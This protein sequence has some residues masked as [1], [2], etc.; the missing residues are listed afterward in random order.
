LESVIP[1]DYVHNVPYVGDD[2]FLAGVDTWGGLISG[3]VPTSDVL[4]IP[5]SPF[6]HKFDVPFVVQKPHVTRY[7]GRVDY[8]RYYEPGSSFFTGFPDKTFNHENDVEHV[9]YRGNIRDIHNDVVLDAPLH[10]GSYPT[11]LI[12]GRP[13][14][15]PFVGLAFDD[16]FGGAKGCARVGTDANGNGIFSLSTG[17]PRNNYRPTFRV[18]QQLAAWDQW[19]HSNSVVTRYLGYGYLYG[20]YENWINKSSTGDGYNR[21]TIDISYDYSVSWDFFQ[22]A[23][24]RSKKLFHVHLVADYEFSSCFGTN[25]PSDLNTPPPQVLNYNV[26]HSVEFVRAD[27]I[28]GSIGYVHDGYLPTYY[29]GDVSIGS[30]LSQEE[31][32]SVPNFVSYRFADKRFLNRRTDLFKRS[33]DNVLGDILPSS[34]LSSADALNK[35]LEALTANHVQTLSQLDGILGLL[36]DLVSLPSLVKRIADGDVGAIRDLIDY[37]TDA[38]LRYRFAQKPNVRNLE[39]ILGTDIGGFLDRL[40]RSTSSTIYGSFKWEFPDDQNFMEDGKLVLETRS[41]VRVTADASTLVESCLMANAVGLL[42]TLSR[43]WETLPFTFVID[44]FFAM[45]KRLKLVD[46]QLAYMAFRTDWCLHSY[47]I[48]YYPSTLA[49][50]AFNLESYDPLEPF[51]ISVYYRHK[52]IYMPRLRNSRY[53]FVAASGANAITAGALAWQLFS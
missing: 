21:G 8:A 36:P 31:A 16:A 19:F 13:G 11:N 24:P 53:D 20:V 17:R 28:I 35:H 51:G 38:I 34:F 49:L 40:G 10:H 3:F 14:L 42:P 7:D 33:V 41:K 1:S 48:V 2:I 32:D 44:W 50:E 43:V 22:T 23:G 52:S 9:A 39:E 5:K 47:K 12:G 37:L 4:G 30:S 29:V 6:E 26:K 25:S 15:I 46:T 18:D 45:N 27:D